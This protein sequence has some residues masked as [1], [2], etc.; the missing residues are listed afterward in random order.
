[1]YRN[2]T[3][4]FLSCLVLASCGFFGRS[5]DVRIAK[6]YNNVLYLSDLDGLVPS[7][8]NSADSA[9]IVQRY[10]DQ[11]IKNNVYL[12]EAK[13]NLS[14][15][16]ADIDRKV[17][18][19]QNSLM[20]FTYENQ[21]LDQKLDTVITQEV[22]QNY[23]E[24]HQHEFPLRN[25]IVKINFVKVP[26]DAPDINMVRK[27]IASSQQD[28][29]NKLEEY[30]IDNAAGYFLDQNSWFIF[31]DILREVP[32]NPANHEQ[33]LRNNKL[34]ELKDEYY[35]YFLYIRDYKMEGTIS[36][37]TFQSDNIK[38]IVL[39]HRKQQLINQ[40]RQELYMKAVKDGAFEIYSK[41]T[42]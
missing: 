13:K 12:N 24:K 4:V 40:L 21:F 1:M 17:A 7:G 25:N 27:L 28:E 20:I 2:I 11:W 35:R 15:N 18:D 37:L 10:I 26:I 38:A 39:N 42:N 16:V 22:L 9:T 41:T 31:T 29:L 23:Y 32:I 6:V 30:C 5:D 14:K 3:I 36:P 34:V 8:T 33:F 19:Y